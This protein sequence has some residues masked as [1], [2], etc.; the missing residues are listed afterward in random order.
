MEVREAY[1]LGRSGLRP[2]VLAGVALALDL[3]R[4]SALALVDLDLHV[5]GAR[6]GGL[7]CVRLLR[8][9]NREHGVALAA[10][11]DAALIRLLLGVHRAAH[12]ALLD[13]DR[14]DLGG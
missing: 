3:D 14:A 4:A 6:E 13:E 11:A 12:V 7:H 10:G 5:A 8:G 9:Q 1:A 2:L